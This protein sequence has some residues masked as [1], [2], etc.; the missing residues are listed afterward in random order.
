MKLFTTKIT[1]VVAL[2]A[3]LAGASVIAQQKP[4]ALTNASIIKLVRAGFK[5]K[6]VIAII[7]SRTNRFDLGPDRLIEL[8][9]NGVS[10]NVILAMLSQDGSAFTGD[11][12]SDDIFFKREEKAT[13]E[14]NGDQKSDGTSI[15][16]SV[17]SPTRGR[18]G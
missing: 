9:H 7:H 11:D 12:L 15:S 1:I 6:T 4:E 2:V 13:P 14:N 16:G 3:V 5:D 10:E 18:S 17:R 8:K